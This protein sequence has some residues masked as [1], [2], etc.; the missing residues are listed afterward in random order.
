MMLLINL[1]CSTSQELIFATYFCKIFFLNSP[2]CLRSNSG[3][4]SQQ[5]VHH[6]SSLHATDLLNHSG[7]SSNQ[8]HTASSLCCHL[9]DATSVQTWCKSH[10]CWTRNQAVQ[11]VSWWTV[12]GALAEKL[13]KQRGGNPTYKC[14][15]RAFLSSCSATG[16]L[17]CLHVTFSTRACAEPKGQN[18]DY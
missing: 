5:G 18:L 11:T 17:I 9:T 7:S 16:M 4:Y 8:P 13:N 6:M 10:R 3:D 12:G 14:T 15:P 1:N 2:F